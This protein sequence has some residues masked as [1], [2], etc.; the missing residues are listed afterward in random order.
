ME[1]TMLHTKAIVTKEDV[2]TEEGVIN[3]VVG[4]TN[5]LDRMGDSIDQAGWVLS[6][7]E[8]NPV[9][10]WGH[11]IH[12]DRPPIG[13]SIKTWIAGKQAKTK[14]LMFKIKF[15]LFDKFA[16]EIYRKIKDG[17]INTVSVGFLPIEW[18][19]REEEG[20]V[21]GRIYTKQELLELSFVPVPAN[22]QALVSLRSMSK[23]DKRFTPVELK[24]LFKEEKE[25]IVKPYP[26]EHS[27]RLVDPSKFQKD[28]FRRVKRDHEGKEYGIIMGKLIGEDTMTEEAYRYN[29]EIWKEAEA[30]KHC[31]DHNGTF[32]PAA[33]KEEIIEEKKEVKKEEK[34][35]KEEKLKKENKEEIKE[36]TNKDEETKEATKKETKEKSEKKE[37]V[38]KEIETKGVIPF[39]D[40]GKAPETE[41]WDGPGEVAKS[42]TKKLKIIC[43]WYDSKNPEKKASYKLPHHRADDNKAV[44]RGVA[45]AMASLLGARGGAKIP[46]QDRKGVYNHLKK[47]YEQF[48]KKAPGFKMVEDQVLASLSDEI[49]SLI[50]EREDKYVV[51]LVKK[52][53]KKQNRTSNTAQIS[54]ALEVINLALSLYKNNS[55]KGGEK[56]G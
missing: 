51:R 26:N 31:K 52:V 8:K 55:L 42:D 45:A 56:K 43:A 46:I 49:Q 39:A 41:G 50:L 34:E 6:H 11:N 21:K 20:A 29:I 7:Y 53:I 5:V 18:H 37:E 24:D 54:K 32:E 33:K 22:P 2:T 17:F 47:H 36:T 19:N 15:D 25:T 1:K 16:A 27:C 35:I 40:Y 38:K 12:Q 28:S 4:S 13:K 9:V 23:T 44:W 30:K 48:D 10:L 14:K 3:A